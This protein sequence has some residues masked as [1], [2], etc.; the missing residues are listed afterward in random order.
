VASLRE[1]SENIEGSLG[2]DDKQHA[3]SLLNMKYAIQSETYHD[4]AASS[5]TSLITQAMGSVSG[6]RGQEAR[7]S[8]LISLG[9]SSATSNLEWASGDGYSVSSNGGWSDRATVLPS[10]FDNVGSITARF[11]MD[12]TSKGG[13]FDKKIGVKAQSG[14]GTYW[15]WQIDHNELSG[16]GTL[17]NGPGDRSMSFQVVND[18]DGVVVGTISG[19]W[20]DPYN[21]RSTSS[22]VVSYDSDAAGISGQVVGKVR[23]SN[24]I[25]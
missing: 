3:Y 7:M 20:F 6:A 25:P 13:H 17:E 1:N 4:G 9:V 23:I 16:L 8:D 10:F 11:P 24:F 21:T 12:E 2:R 22:T 19:W 14:A 15:R 18:S 5:Q